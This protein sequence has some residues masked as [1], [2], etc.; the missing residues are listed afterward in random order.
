MYSLQPGSNTRPVSLEK[1]HHMTIDVTDS[2]LAGAIN[3]DIDSDG[4]STLIFSDGREV[5]LVQGRNQLFVN[6]L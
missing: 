6:P 3:L 2:C 1:I 5:E 4:S